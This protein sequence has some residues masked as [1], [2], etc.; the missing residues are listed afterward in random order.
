MLYA[1]ENKNIGPMIDSRLEFGTKLNVLTGDNSLG[2]SFLLDL[3]WFGITR[4]WPAEINNKV[5]NGFCARPWNIVNPA[6]LVY[7]WGDPARL[8]NAQKCYRN[9]FYYCKLPRNWRI[10]QHDKKTRYA[11]LAIYM[12][13]DGSF[14]VYDPLRNGSIGDVY[15]EKGSHREA[16]I[17][18]QSDLWP[19]EISQQ[20][21]FCR[22]VLADWA[23]WQRDKNDRLFGCLKTVVES[24]CP[25]EDDAKILE[26]D[27]APIERGGDQP[28]LKLPTG[29]TRLKYAS[30]AVRRMAALAYVLVWAVSEH[31]RAAKD[32]GVGTNK[33]IFILL[34]E[35]ESHL[36]PRWQRSCVKGVM[37]AIEKLCEATDYGEHSV[38]AFVSTHSPLV[39]ASL[40]DAFYKLNEPVGDAGDAKAIPNCKWFDFDIDPSQR[41]EDGREV[42][43]R[44]RDF[45]PHG[46]TEGWLTSEAFNL[47]PTAMYSPDVEALID[48]LNDIFEHYPTWAR[49]RAV[50]G[51]S[52]AEQKEC[53]KRKVRAL[54]DRLHPGDVY[55]YVFDHK[56][57][58]ALKTETPLS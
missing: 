23:F 53:L 9:V 58:Q 35:I 29:A 12:M 7:K 39:M 5:A 46:T 48:E 16:Y 51:M 47:K 34:D 56:L 27:S 17:L 14:A 57:Q 13:A 10:D 28:V 41:S 20:C 6:T 15:S 54:V 31:L 18:S 42:V 33:Q 43:V 24:L 8:P 37:T 32:L 45:E 11:G 55:G 4:C 22:G 50:E 1:F 30:S 19:N 49:K 2:K 21:E 3:V 36:H 52:D 44:E 25:Q 38:Q 26:L 40:E